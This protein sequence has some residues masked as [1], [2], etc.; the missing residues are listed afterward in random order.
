[1]E[2]TEDLWGSYMKVMMDNLNFYTGTELLQGLYIRGLLACG[3][4]RAKK[5]SI[6]YKVSVTI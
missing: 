5:N 3:T 4:G 6:I 1:M 2:L